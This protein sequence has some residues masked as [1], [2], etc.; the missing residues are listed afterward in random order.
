MNDSTQVVLIEDNISDA[1]ITIRALRKNKLANSILH[2]TD[3]RQAL[4]YFFSQ[5]EYSEQPL[6]N[7]PRV[8][9]LDLKMPKLS[10]F[11]VL[12]QL[13]TNPITRSIPVVILTSSNEDPDIERCY[14]LGVN[15]YVVKPMGFEEFNK[16]IQQLGL[17]WLVV[18]QV[19]KNR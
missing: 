18:N 1:D 10:G 5:G 2:L 19:V 11:E 16:A 7:F 17:Y 14:A 15:S 4:D 13:R 9:F 3:G 12:Q 6:L 8:I